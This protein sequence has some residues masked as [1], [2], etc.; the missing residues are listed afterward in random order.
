[1]HNVNLHQVP[2]CLHIVGH[3]DHL[4]PTLGYRGYRIQQME[5]GMLVQ[6]LLL[7]ASALGMGGHPLLG[8]ESGMCDEL[9]QFASHGLTC[10]IQVPVG[11]YRTG[12]RLEGRLHT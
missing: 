12:S 4:I 7:T 9:Y 6:R 5:T 10:L 8:Y 1:M 3:R 11:P 2:L